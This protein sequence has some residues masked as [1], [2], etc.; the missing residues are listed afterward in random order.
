MGGG[1]PTHLAGRS[2]AKER[3]SRPLESAGRCH[4]TYYLPD[5]VKHKEGRR[6]DAGG[7]KPTDEDVSSG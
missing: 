3:P 4:H 1:R 5:H 7:L 6:Q 2:N